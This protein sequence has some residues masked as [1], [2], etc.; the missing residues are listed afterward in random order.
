MAQ[1]GNG[2]VKQSEAQSTHCK[3]PDLIT[4]RA[5]RGNDP[6]RSMMDALLFTR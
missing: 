4:E 6:S 2:S 5:F 1:S 3:K